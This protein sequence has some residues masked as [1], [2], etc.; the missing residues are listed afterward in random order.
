MDST[1][2]GALSKQFKEMGMHKYDIMLTFRG[3]NAYA[4]PFRKE[5]EANEK[6]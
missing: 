1:N 6:Q 5:S 2:T 3:F 4:E